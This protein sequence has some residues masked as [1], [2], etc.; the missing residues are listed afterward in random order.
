[1][2]RRRQQEGKLVT[3]RQVRDRLFRELETN[4]LRG[5]NRL[6]VSGRGEL[7]LGIL[8]ETMRRRLRVSSISTQV[9]KSGQP[10]EPEC[11]VLDVP[12]DGVGSCIERLGQR[13]G[14]MQDM[15]VGGNGRT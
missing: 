4:A 10:C 11:L 13:R 2:I 8:I 5:R 15:L 1:M 7:H 12:E 9:G 3:S 14:E 6:P